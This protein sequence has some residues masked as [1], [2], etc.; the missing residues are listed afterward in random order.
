MQE[1]GIV[2]GH[3]L[4]PPNPS[5]PSTHFPRRLVVKGGDLKIERKI[6]LSEFPLHLFLPAEEEG[7]G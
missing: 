7:E 1:Y 2:R 3:D 6:S 5:I 4:P